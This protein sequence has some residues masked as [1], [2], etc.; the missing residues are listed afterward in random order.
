MLPSIVG[1]GPGPYG[2]HYLWHDENGD[3][4]ADYVGQYAFVKG[5]MTL[6]EKHSIEKM[7]LKKFVR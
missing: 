2:I 3:G 4:N 5:K 6:I 7:P 1:Q